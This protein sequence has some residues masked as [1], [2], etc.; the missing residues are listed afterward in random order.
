M[1]AAEDTTDRGLRETAGHLVNPDA[2]PDR[3][4]E[5]FLEAVERSGEARLP[6]LALAYAAGAGEANLR[7]WKV[8]WRF[9]PGFAVLWLNVLEQ[10]G[11]P[12]TE[13]EAELRTHWATQPTDDEDDP[14]D[15]DDPDGDLEGV[16]PDTDAPAG[17][18]LTEADPSDGPVEPVDDT[19]SDG[20]DAA[21]GGAVEASVED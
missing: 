6:L 10:L 18:G 11:Y 15:P 12:L 8:S 16:L 9:T 2:E 1:L 14:D 3:R 4:A 17:D 19:D 7:A 13:V 21:D 20:D 5:A